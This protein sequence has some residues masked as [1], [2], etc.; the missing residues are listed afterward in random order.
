MHNVSLGQLKDVLRLLRLMS[1]VSV[2]TCVILPNT[3][4]LSNIWT[5][6]VAV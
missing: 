1:S 5:P 4:L 2:L 3:S 6:G